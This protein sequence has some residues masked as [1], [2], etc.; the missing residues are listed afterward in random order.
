M[1]LC[2]V[3]ILF[4]HRAHIDRY[5][6]YR[7]TNNPTTARLIPWQRRFLEYGNLYT[8]PCQSPRRDRT[9]R[10]TT[11]HNDVIRETHR[12]HTPLLTMTEI[13]FIQ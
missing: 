5:G 11:D 9:S 12:S 7:T 13:F 8:C 10:A 6:L 2:R 3:T 1:E 4:D